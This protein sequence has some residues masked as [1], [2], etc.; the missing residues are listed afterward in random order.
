MDSLTER[1]KAPCGLL[2][3]RLLLTKKSGARRSWLRLTCLSKSSKSAGS[4]WC[5]GSASASE[6]AERLGLLV[7][8]AERAASE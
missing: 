7:L 8:C 3:L 4:T 5:G 2:L 6:G 1:T